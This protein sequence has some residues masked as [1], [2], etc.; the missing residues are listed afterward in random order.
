MVYIESKNECKKINADLKY[1]A[2]TFLKI[3]EISASN[4]SITYNMFLRAEEI[5]LDYNFKRKKDHV[6]TLYDTAKKANY[7]VKGMKNFITR[8]INSFQ[9]IKQNIETCI[10]LFDEIGARIGGENKIEHLVK[11]GKYDE[12]V[13]V[14]DV[15]FNTVDTAYI[16]WKEKREKKDVIIIQ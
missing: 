8:E 5:L 13:N 15:Y 10:E 11:T 4:R 6:L 1:E 2:M 9:N 16:L 3:L 14:F 12:I 7:I